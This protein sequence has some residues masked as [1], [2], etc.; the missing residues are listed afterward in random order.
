MGKQIRLKNQTIKITECALGKCPAFLPM[1][2][3]GY[4]DPPDRCLFDATFEKIGFYKETKKDASIPVDCPLE[5]E[6]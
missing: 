5:D 6:E 3:T 4:N 2:D 1:G